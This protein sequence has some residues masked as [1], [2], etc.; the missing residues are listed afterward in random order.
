MM[1]YLFAQ[2]MMLLCYLQLNVLW[3]KMMDNVCEQIN[4][5]HF[6]VVDNPW[7][8]LLMLNSF[9]QQYMKNRHHHHPHHL[10]MRIK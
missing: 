4:L 6:V 5:I 9:D 7:L 1:D 10:M 8:Y 2:M 3:M